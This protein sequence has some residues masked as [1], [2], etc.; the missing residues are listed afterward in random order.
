MKKKKKDQ[1]YKINKFLVGFF[2]PPNV[3]NEIAQSFVHL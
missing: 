3:K 2:L 1:K